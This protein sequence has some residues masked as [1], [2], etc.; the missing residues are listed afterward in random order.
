MNG[1]FNETNPNIDVPDGL[2][3]EFSLKGRDFDF[4]VDDIRSIGRERL[5]RYNYIWSTM[6]KRAYELGVRDG[7][8]NI[9]KKTLGDLLKHNK[10][11][12]L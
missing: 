1:V 10:E 2:M 7:K 6:L 9:L 8:E 3:W 5:E 12:D 4:R 11:F